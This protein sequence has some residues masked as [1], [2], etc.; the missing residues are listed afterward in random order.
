MTA[1]CAP[2]S[3]PYL[4][5]LEARKHIRRGSGIANILLSL[6]FQVASVSS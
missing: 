4:S 6:G 2:D 5:D 1:R 3:C